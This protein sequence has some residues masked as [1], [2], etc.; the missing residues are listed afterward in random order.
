MNIINKF[1]KKVFVISCYPTSE[2]LNDLIPFLKKEEI[3]YELVIGP[4]QKYFTFDGKKSLATIGALSLISANESIYLNAK[5]NQ[6]ENFCVIE[7]DIVFIPEYKEKLSAFFDKVP[8]DWQIINLGYH[9]NSSVNKKMDIN[10]VFYKLE[11]REPPYI[12]G[13]TDEVVG[14]HFVAYKQE[15]LDT[16]IDTL[17]K[18]RFPMDWFLTREIYHKFDVYTCCEKI[19]YSS[20]YRNEAS[21]RTKDYAF[22]KSAI[23]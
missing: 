4:K 11:K 1:F 13:V 21:R 17:D 2:R 14:T 5:I 23:N 19:F 3:D 22:Y 20:S 15:T 16:I 8:N 10:N 9:K 18:S 6:Y 7:D 12:K